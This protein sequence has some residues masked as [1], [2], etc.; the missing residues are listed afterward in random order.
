MFTKIINKIK[1][2]VKKNK[3]KE[4]L[5][6]EKR[7]VFIDTSFDKSKFFKRKKQI[8]F[9]FP[10]LQN[11]YIKNNLKMLYLG[12]I[13]TFLFLIVVSLFTPIFYIQKI[14]ITLYDKQEGL[15]DLNIAYDLL[16]NYR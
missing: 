8:T 2:K 3:F 4:T 14:N 12:I 1:Q 16:N 7:K 13:F 10:K 9:N 11:N 6:K 15:I 5:K